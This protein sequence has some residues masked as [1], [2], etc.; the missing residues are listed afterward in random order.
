M[1]GDGPGIPQDMSDRALYFKVQAKVFETEEAAQGYVE[2]LERRV[3][4]GWSA[5]KKHWLVQKAFFIHPT[6]VKPAEKD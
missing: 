6:L 5:H 1:V 2:E 4:H 3:R